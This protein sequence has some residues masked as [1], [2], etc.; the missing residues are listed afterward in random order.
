MGGEIHPPTAQLPL[1]GLGETRSGTSN[2][3][4]LLDERIKKSKASNRLPTPQAQL[5]PIMYA[6]KQKN[7][8]DDDCKNVAI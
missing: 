2:L 5:I 4:E 3:N 8:G 6:S 1:K 7:G